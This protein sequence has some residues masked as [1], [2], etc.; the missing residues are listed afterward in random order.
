[1]N[2]PPTFGTSPNNKKPLG[3][4]PAE[5][6]RKR[7]Y[8]VKVINSP[9]NGDG[10]IRRK[11]AEHYVSVG[12]AEWVSA[13]QVRM[14]GSHPQNS[15]AASRAAEGYQSVTRTMTLEELAHVPLVNPRIAYTNR[16]IPASRHFAGRSGPVRVVTD[17]H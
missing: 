3:L 4:V 5:R 10:L 11:K 13:D 6:E 1:M 2:S 16:S 12:R 14:I 15:T 8:R 9:W 17:K 7:S